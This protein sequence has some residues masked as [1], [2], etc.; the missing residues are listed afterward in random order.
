MGLGCPRMT[1]FPTTALS[2]AHKLDVIEVCSGGTGW[3]GVQVR[4]ADNHVSRYGE[5]LVRSYRGS[6][7]IVMSSST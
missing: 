1:L 5:E 3:V 2:F 4:R 6:C 7:I